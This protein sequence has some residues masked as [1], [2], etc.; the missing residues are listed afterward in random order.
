M[1][2]GTALV[3]AACADPSGPDELEEQIVFVSTR[4]GVPAPNGF[5]S[6]SE[7]YRMNADGSGVENLTK[8]PGYY[9]HLNVTPDGRTLVFSATREFPASWTGAT[10]PDQIWRMGVD[11]SEPRKLITGGACR[12]NPRLS[13]DGSLIAF[14]RDKDV[15]V[16]TIEGKN[17]RI[18]SQFLP[19][20]PSTA[21]GATPKFDVRTQ[22]WV[23]ADR[24]MFSRFI[25]GS[26]TTNY[27]VKTDGTALTELP[28]DT[29]VAYVSPDRTRLVSRVVGMPS[30]QALAVMK[31]DG[32]DPRFIGE[33]MTLPGR[34]DADRTP[35]S[36]DGTRFYV[37]TTLNHYISSVDGALGT[38]IPAASLEGQ[39]SGWSRRGDM[40]LF[41]K[42]RPGQPAGQG[43]NDVWVMK[44]D[45][46]GITNLTATA[47][48]LNNTPVFA[49]KR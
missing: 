14:D 49:Y 20:V 28:F 4:D 15:W 6:L 10:C 42:I 17:E 41:S 38:P 7:I 40:L 36:P 43:I 1:I 27:A 34:F 12:S 37:R 19:P 23:S 29:Q 2:A 22:G 18:V 8:S 33:G 9:H 11:G 35:W 3:A 26:G 21:C 25:C 31:P 30:S 5:G 16:M 47:T 13:P 39:F 45:G 32:T 24:V 48:G 44:A 46:S